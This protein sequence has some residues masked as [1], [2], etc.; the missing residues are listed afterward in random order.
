MPTPKQISATTKRPTVLIEIFGISVFL[1][2]M[3]VAMTQS[4]FLR[5]QTSTNE[6]CTSTAECPLGYACTTDYGDCN[7]SQACVPGQPCIA[8][9]TGFCV[10]EGQVTTPK[11]E[12]S[13]TLDPTVKIQQKYA[14]AKRCT[15]GVNTECGLLLWLS[16]TEVDGSLISRFQNPLITMHPWSFEMN[17]YTDAG[18]LPTPV[19]NPNGE[20]TA[21]SFDLDR[22]ED[23]QHPYSQYFLLRF[24]QGNEEVRWTVEIVFGSPSL[25]PAVITTDANEVYTPKQSDKPQSTQQAASS[26]SSSSEATSPD[27]P[28]RIPAHKLISSDTPAGYY[29]VISRLKS[30]YTCPPCLPGNLCK[31]CAPDHIILQDR[32]IMVLETPNASEFPLDET[33]DITVLKKIWQNSVGEE[34]VS[35]TY[36]DHQV[37]RPTEV[38]P[39]VEILGSTFPDLE[40][41]SLISQAAEV[42]KIQGV[43]KGYPDGTFGPKRHV[44]RAEAAKMLLEAKYGANIPDLQNTGQFPDVETG[45]WYTKYVMYAAQLGIINGYPDG[46]FRPG[47][48]INTAEFLKMIT[49]TFGID[50]NYPYFFIDVEED[51]WFDEF[52]GATTVF[53]LL[54]LRPY[55]ALWPDMLMT[56]EEVAIAIYNLQERLTS[57]L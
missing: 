35:Y 28:Q 7:A 43:I 15:D 42:L 30:A 25:I 29:T 19:Y 55:Y 57:D 47:G 22:L 36:V 2:V 53:E 14:A 32:D 18:L 51:D 9:C 46:S 34:V 1:G 17:S 6:E 5:A 38:H 21:M 4:S 39:P 52:A 13:P 33:F 56:R 48:K 26:A 20:I 10:P 24:L 49:L 27:E 31:P 16:L 40:E 45:A 44:I 3:C 11:N 37:N 54:P 8:V 50:R 12:G 23:V 41:G